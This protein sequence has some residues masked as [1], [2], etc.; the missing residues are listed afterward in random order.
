ML[1]L[2][3]TVHIHECI[4]TH[5]HFIYLRIVQQWTCITFRF[6]HFVSCFLKS[7][8]L[9]RFLPHVNNTHFVL[10]SFCGGNGCCGNYVLNIFAIKWQTPGIKLKSYQAIFHSQYFMYTKYT[11][12]VSHFLH[13]SKLQLYWKLTTKKNLFLTFT[14]IIL[15]LHMH[16]SHFISSF[17]LTLLSPW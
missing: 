11:Q 17:L 14:L 8:F 2:L 3:C 6:C 5:F 1:I 15:V 12:L 4:H 16:V 9:N 10:L 13:N 7:L